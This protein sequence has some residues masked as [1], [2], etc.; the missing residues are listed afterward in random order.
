MLW[1]VISPTYYSSLLQ[2]GHSEKSIKW[3]VF[4]CTRQWTLLLP[5]KEWLQKRHV[6]VPGCLWHR[7]VAWK[8]KGAHF[9]EC[10]RL[11][12]L[13][14]Q[15]LTDIWQ[16]GVVRRNSG[17]S[18]RFS[19]LNFLRT[20]VTGTSRL[21]IYISWEGGLWIWIPL[22]STNHLQCSCKYQPY[23]WS[24]KGQLGSITWC[25]YLHGGPAG[26]NSATFSLWLY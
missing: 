11:K 16:K 25:A 17:S 14:L 8:K 20:L 4:G 5:W 6:T 21:P 13:L 26:L 12:L 3:M 15:I 24:G 19:T 9:I 10:Y 18:E 22:Q 23:K 1:L 2:E 7:H